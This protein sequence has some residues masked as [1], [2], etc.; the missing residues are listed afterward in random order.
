[1]NPIDLAGLTL[2]HFIWQGTII[3][4]AAM[5]LLQILRRRSSQARY[6]V[7]CAALVMMVA[8]PAGTALSLARSTTI[9][10]PAPPA[11]TTP[12]SGIATSTRVLGSHPEATVGSTV[13]ANASHTP[14]LSIIVGIWMAGVSVL[15]A[16]VAASWWSVRRLHRAAFTTAPS[17]F[18]AQA[19]RL[20][21]RLGL[22]RAL[23]V[24]D[25][26]DVDTPTVVGW[27]KPAILLPVAAMANLTPAQVDAILAHEL[28]HVR[29]HDSLV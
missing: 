11:S 2:L 24:V 12:S 18:I 6:A 20:S 28:A 14:W 8:A 15:L 7:A 3:G 19:E 26:I 21:S 22:H 13:D 16:R 5:V 10:L 29:R 27:L 9:S 1:M 23:R 4:A 17:Q 25:S